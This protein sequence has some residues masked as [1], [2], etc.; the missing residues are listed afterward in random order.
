M[1]LHPFFYEEATSK[2]STKKGLLY[3]LEESGQERFK[4]LS[5]DTPLW[6]DVMSTSLK[7][8][9]ELEKGMLSDHHWLL[10][11][12]STVFLCHW[13]QQPIKDMMSLGTDFETHAIWQGYVEEPNAR[14]FVVR[15]ARTIPL[16]EAQGAHWNVIRCKECLANHPEAVL[17]QATID[18][19]SW[20]WKSLGDSFPKLYCIDLAEAYVMQESASSRILCEKKRYDLHF[21]NGRLHQNPLAKDGKGK[22]NLCWVYYQVFLSI[23]L[24]ETHKFCAR[25]MG[26][27]VQHTTSKCQRYKK[28][29]QEIG[30]PCSR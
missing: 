11:V 9:E 17:G 15:K 28:T 30:F 1:L 23:L 14:D 20:V 6:C 26:V 19:D 3:A 12:T 10:H 24:W 13:G 25:N 27:H 16:S 21:P 8:P 29:G 18:L 2:S 7:N 22:E 5:L 4:P